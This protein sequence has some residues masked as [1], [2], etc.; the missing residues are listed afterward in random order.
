MAL[1][2]GVTVSASAEAAP[3]PR[4]APTALNLDI[5]GFN[6]GEPYRLRGAEAE[7][8]LRDPSVVL[9]RF[10]SRDWMQRSTEGSLVPVADVVSRFP[11]RSPA[12]LVSVYRV[13]LDGDKQHEVL[14]FAVADELT[15]RHRYAPTVL[16]LTD[17]G[18]EPHWIS[19]QLP[20]ER[21]SLV[22]VRDLNS[23]GHLEM[24]LSGEAGHSGYYRFHQL[25]GRLGAKSVVLPVKHV[26]SVH[27][28]DLDRDQSFEIV[29][30]K[31][32]GRRG[33]ASQWTY[34]DRLMRWTGEGF[35]DADEAFPGYHDLETLPALV[36][37]LI[38]HYTATA[39]I[40]EEKVDA[41]EEVRGRVL[42]TVSRPK[43]FGKE[44]VRALGDVQKGRVI[45]GREALLRLDQQYPYEPQLLLA[46][47]RV[48]AREEAWKR[49]LDLS[50]RTLTVDPRDREAWWWAAV[51]FVNLEERSSA[52][53]SLHLLTLLGPKRADGVAFLQARRGE[54]GME[55][56]LQQ[57][58]DEAIATFQSK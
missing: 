40:L 56:T 41:I 30:R 14:L 27:Y 19:D 17:R 46:L 37:N 4:P 12:E 24:L 8:V 43:G 26:D 1:L 11:A 33:P 47:A 9:F 32:V 39:P 5:L 7:A 38:D 34:V 52:L 54:P 51:S 20:G 28:V 16:R 53:A 25:V 50:I 42:T 49:V 2:M 45:V 23:D 29:L 31:R 58:I 21:H 36:S 10:Q 18:Y 57:V 48:F 15:R 6:E 35:E 22:D 13:D 55:G 44:L 3:R